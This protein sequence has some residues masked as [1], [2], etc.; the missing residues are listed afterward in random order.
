[1]VCL[2]EEAVDGVLEVGDGSEHALETPSCELGEEAFD[3]I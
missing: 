2:C 3:G 1:M